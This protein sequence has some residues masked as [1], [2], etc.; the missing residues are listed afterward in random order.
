MD[1]FIS[2]SKKDRTFAYRIA[3]DL[4]VA[5]FDVW[6]DRSLG[7]GDKWEEMIEHQL[8]QA[9]DVI[10]ILSD[11]SL[12]SKWVM[13]EGSMA[14]AL[15]KNIYPL[16]ICEIT[17]G[18]L[19]IWSQKIQYQQFM[20]AKY[21]DALRDLI[22]RLT[23]VNPLNRLLIKQYEIFSQTNVLPSLEFMKNTEPALKEYPIQSQAI[24]DIMFLA[25]LKYGLH[26][27]FWVDFAL[28]NQV[29]IFAIIE[30]HIDEYDFH[31]RRVAIQAL[32]LITPDERSDIFLK[33]LADPYPQVRKEAIQTLMQFPVMRA[34]LFES[35]KHERYVPAGTFNMGMDELPFFDEHGHALSE[36][37]KQG[38]PEYPNH[39]VLMDAYFIDK[40]PVTNQDYL[41]FLLDTQP[42]SAKTELFSARIEGKQD[43]A[44]TDLDWD[45]ACEYAFWA[46]KKLPTEATWEKA[47]RGP[48]SY[49][50]PWGNYFDSG[51]AHTR[52][53]RKNGLMPVH[54]FS[55]HGDSYYQ[56]ANMVGNV[57][58]WV[59]DWYQEDYYRTQN[60]YNNPAGPPHGKLKVLRGGS[61]LET[62]DY[63][64]CYRRIGRSPAYRAKDIGFRC[65]FE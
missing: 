14:Y 11:N 23:P 62:A 18:D 15:K 25:A 6:I 9:K 5:G 36:F 17:P 41:R 53:S 3:D 51:K 55:P 24:A 22:G 45:E 19:P 58:E 64:N 10:V 54:A 2:Y 46:G 40:Y 37:D 12:K 1:I 8:D 34:R 42:G 30:D 65:A 26:V 61:Y 29:D 28:K 47:A 60:S 16:L 49:L 21:E 31:F 63:A 4:T 52:E 56:V 35:L 59:G 57:W 39:E 27:D 44:I 33:F 38:F 20:G 13:H 48:E 50:F 32:R 7:V 43:I